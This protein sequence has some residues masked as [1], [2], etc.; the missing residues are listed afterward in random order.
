MRDPKS[1]R[2]IPFQEHQQE[3]DQIKAVTVI[4]LVVITWLQ[5][6][7]ERGFCIRGYNTVCRCWG[8]KGKES[9]RGEEGETRGKLHKTA[10]MRPFWARGFSGN[11]KATKV[12][13]FELLC[14]GI[15][16]W[17]CPGVGILTEPQA[18]C[19]VW[20]EVLTSSRG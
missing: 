8:R 6:K 11:C 10:K 3:E 15:S 17:G 14:L 18:S 7:A 13:S 9:A 19:P 12:G 5:V 16:M 20:A 1:G 4:F 2:E